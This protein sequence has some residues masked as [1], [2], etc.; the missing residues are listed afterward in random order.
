[1]RRASR[2]SAGRFAIVSMVLSLCAA[3][4]WPVAA[5]A[6]A[7]SWT[8]QLAPATPTTPTGWRWTRPAP[9]R[10]RPRRASCP[11]RRPSA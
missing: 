2:S 4:L 10:D 3:V 11:A 5:P 9:L 1:M 8:A 6:A 7:I